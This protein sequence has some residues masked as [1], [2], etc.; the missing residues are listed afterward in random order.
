MDK[1]KKENVQNSF[2]RNTIQKFMKHRVAM[3]S[4]LFLTVEILAVI[5]LP[6]LMDLD[7][8]TTNAGCFSMAPDERFL[9]GTDEGMCFPG[10]STE[11]ES[12][13]W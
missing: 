9:L 11:A 8:Y 6:L 12:P 2:W 4:L 5:L 1:I 13:S 3:F 10:L 7:P